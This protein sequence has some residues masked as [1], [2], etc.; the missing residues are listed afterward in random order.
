MVAATVLGLVEKSC[1][2]E[3]QE[4]ESLP[5]GSHSPLTSNPN[6]SNRIGCTCKSR[7][8]ISTSTIAPYA[9]QCVRQWRATAVAERQ[10]RERED[11]VVSEAQTYL[12]RLR[13]QR[14]L[15]TWRGCAKDEISKRTKEARADS[16]YHHVLQMKGF[17]AWC[18]NHKATLRKKHLSKLSARF[19][20]SRV[21][22]TCYAKWRIQVRQEKVFG[23]RGYICSVIIIGSLWMS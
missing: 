2:G 9:F 5:T 3:T 7:P 4:Q 19:N 6:Q 14:L 12:L 1:E 23:W 13:A 22:S 18:D 17:V 8:Y 20:N 21:L 10:Q 16:H 15:H 11:E